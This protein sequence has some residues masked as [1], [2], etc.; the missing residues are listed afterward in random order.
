[1]RNKPVFAGYL[2]LTA[3]LAPGIATA[4]W[5]ANCSNIAG[6]R[7][8]TPG[9]ATY[10]DCMNYVNMNVTAQSSCNCTGFD[11]R[12]AEEGVNAQTPADTP[13]VEPAPDDSAHQ[14]ELKLER[15]KKHKKLVGSLKR[16]GSSGDA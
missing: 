6:A 2:Y 5:T 13:T 8:S 3:L 1:M 4:S 15:E 14:E 12:P 16:I 11:D 10:T 9:F 7:W